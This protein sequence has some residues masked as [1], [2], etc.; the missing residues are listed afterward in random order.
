MN[1]QEY[2]EYLKSEEWEFSREQKY[3]FHGEKDEFGRFRCE[4]C[5]L[6]FHRCRLEV[7]HVTYE[8]IGR[9]RLGDLRILCESCHGTQH[10]EQPAWWH[11]QKMEQ[12]NR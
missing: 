9:E 4:E 10:G 5:S 8:R 7:H 3:L 6:Y 12:L 1:K 11:V 2:A